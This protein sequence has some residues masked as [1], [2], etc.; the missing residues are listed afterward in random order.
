MR[1][2]SV[3]VRAFGPFHGER[4]DLARGLT[5]VAG[6]NEAGKSTWHAAVR[7]A[8]CG[9]PRRRGRPTSAEQEFADLHR[10]WDRPGEW[11]VAARLAL[12]ANERRVEIRQ[13]LGERL[14]STAIELPIGRTVSDEIL[15]DG[16]PD[17]SRWLGLDRDAFAA[18]VCVDQ[19]D[20]LAVTRAAGSLQQHLQR[21]AATRGSDATAAEAIDRLRRFRSE[22]VGLDRPNAVRPL[23]QATEW[24]DGARRVLEDARRQHDEYLRLA[25][26]ADEARLAHTR[27][28]LRLRVVEAAAARHD[29]TEVAER[30]RRARAL[31]TRHPAEPDGAPERD[32]L[33]DEVA[34]AIGGWIGRPA[35][36]VLQ[37]PTASELDAQLQA[38][39]EVPPGDLAVD[40]VVREAREA[41]IA[42][43]DAVLLLGDEPAVP[44]GPGV[45]LSSAELG[46]LV[47]DLEARAPDVDPALQPVRDVARAR[48]QTAERTRSLAGLGALAAGV[49]AAILAVVGMYP[50]AAAGAVVAV[51]VAAAY[52]RARGTA[53]LAADDLR[54]A[55]AGLA[56]WNLA[57]AAADARRADA[58]SRLAAAGV[59]DPLPS[60]VRALAAEAAAAE[61]ATRAR[62][63][64][65]D[66][67]TL[68]ERR[69]GEAE[70]R[71]RAALFSRGVQ[72][73]DGVG[74]SFR[75]YEAACAQRA[76]LM[77]EASRAAALASALASRHQAE[78]QTQAVLQATATARAA[79]VRCASLA[80]CP[81]D[82]RSEDALVEAL[83]AWQRRRAEDLRVAAEGRTEWE[84]L[85]AILGG[86]SVEELE[87]V[88]T[89]LARA[90]EERE[91]ELAALITAAQGDADPRHVDRPDA[92]PDV[93][94][95]SLEDDTTARLAHL[96]AEERVA[97]DAARSL[98]GAA[99]DRAGRLRDVAE[100]EEDLQRAQAELERVRRL[101]A[102]LATTIALLEQAQERVHRDIAPVLAA[103]IRERLGEL[104]AGRYDEAAVDPASLAVRVRERTTGRWRD[105]HR[106]SMGTR[107]QVYLLL[108]SAMAQHL[109]TTG[110]TAPLLLDEVTAQA[111]ERRKVAMLDVLHTMS[112]ER[113]VI[114][115]THDREVVAWANLH[116]NGAEDRLVE[117]PDR[118]AD[119]S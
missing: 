94:P 60:T 44:P 7:A 72:T 108:R 36:P 24:R 51:A 109:V 80:D 22:Q 39:P 26:D 43:R 74:A 31:A 47:A 71:L 19:A 92:P 93:E 33:A 8:I 40:A 13:D 3:T 14:D 28:L 78:A 107:E 58:V 105:A 67:T 110:E 29:A 76:A 6:P 113:Q 21:A 115:F 119:A 75:D 69:V 56:P 86:R 112:R 77:A 101:D 16:S 25:A 2:E 98:A 117:L 50:L 20:I 83:R 82:G 111:D 53:A 96:A 41:W 12:D 102:T 65:E 85:Q 49:L 90:A 70:S 59:P 32:R 52:V 57:R 34:A 30:A 9:L 54:Q 118:M 87:L 35:V 23:R 89:A 18:T 27:A 99:E 91:R 61:A 116:L 68:A 38:L 46:S 42:A 88:A 62:A 37:G 1:V 17:A 79:L 100:A 73:G 64:W 11:S 104:T 5:V 45:G 106:L 55:E 10:P 97:L 114:L 103:A 84:Q 15:T 48:K 81:T 66:R 63:E 4:L 95:A